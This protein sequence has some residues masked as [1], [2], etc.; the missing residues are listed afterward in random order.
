LEVRQKKAGLNYK[1]PDAL[2]R[3]FFISTITRKEKV[4]A[5]ALARERFSFPGKALSGLPVSDLQSN[6]IGDVRFRG[7]RLT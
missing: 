7:L 3:A 2:H 4:A 5:P 6:S 1:T